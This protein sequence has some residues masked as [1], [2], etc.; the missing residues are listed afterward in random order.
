MDHD[1]ALVASYT[2]RSIQ[3]RPIGQDFENVTA[4]ASRL[5]RCARHILA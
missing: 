5:C 3:K 4:I 2:G 1:H